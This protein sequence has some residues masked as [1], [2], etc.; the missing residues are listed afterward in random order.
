MERKKIEQEIYFM[1]CGS[2]IY[3]WKELLKTVTGLSFAQIKLQDYMSVMVKNLK[4]YT[5]NMNKMAEEI[6]QSK[7]KKF[8]KPLSKVKLKQELHI[9]FLKITLTLNQINRI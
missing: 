3:S 5:L 9:C 4:N 1:L 8:G 6:K 7:H 2:L